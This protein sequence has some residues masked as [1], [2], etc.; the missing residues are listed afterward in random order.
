MNILNKKN[1]GFSL[2]ELILAIAIFSLSSIA[3]ATLLIDSN[4]SSRLSL[5]KTYALLYAKEG[6]EATRSIRDNNWL[7][8]ADGDHGLLNNG[9]TWVFSGSSDLIDDKYTRTITL[10][11]VSTTTKNVLIN[12]DWSL[13]PSRLANVNLETILTNWKE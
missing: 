9:V 10:T 1:N 12:I 5:E 7:D 11:T 4:I 8:L 13:T 6:L 3:M 2:L